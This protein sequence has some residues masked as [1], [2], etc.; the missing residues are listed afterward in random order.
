VLTFKEK[1][2]E[3]KKEQVKKKKSSNKT[4]TLKLTVRGDVKP[5]QE[6]KLCVTDSS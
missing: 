5:G 4:D 6:E 3:E 2:E 1:R